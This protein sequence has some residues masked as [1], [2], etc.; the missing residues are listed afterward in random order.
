MTMYVVVPTEGYPYIKNIKSGEQEL[1]FLQ[2]ILKGYIELLS[3]QIYVNTSILNNSNKWLTKLFCNGGID[4]IEIYVNEDGMNSLQ[5]NDSLFTPYGP[6]FGNVVIK[7]DKNDFENTEHHDSV[8]NTFEDMLKVFKVF[9]KKI[10][11]SF[12]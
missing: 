12:N 4:D 1:D 3:G 10:I 7:I 11:K 9:K 2:G 6:I 8:F 5:T